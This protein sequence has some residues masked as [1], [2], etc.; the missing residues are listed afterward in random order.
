[1][2]FSSNLHKLKFVVLAIYKIAIFVLTWKYWMFLMKAS[3]QMKHGWLYNKISRKSLLNTEYS[4]SQSNIFYN[5]KIQTIYW[6]NFTTLD[7]TL[8]GCCIRKQKAIVSQNF[9]ISIQLSFL[10][11]DPFRL[12]NRK[13]LFHII[14]TYMIFE[15]HLYSRTDWSTNDMYKV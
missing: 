11:F 9:V 2:F 4:Y 7:V 6:N 10:Y 5:L 3:I 15:I 1:M 14:H 8:N 13:S 12:K